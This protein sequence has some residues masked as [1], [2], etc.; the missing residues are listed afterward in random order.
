MKADAGAAPEGGGSK[1]KM[2]VI[3]LVALIAVAAGA[4]ITWFLANRSSA[5]AAAHKPVKLEPPVFVPI[6]PFTV[7]LQQETGEQYLQTA[8]TLQVSGVE[9]MQVIKDN[10]PQVRSR[11]LL[12]LSSKK[13]SE[14]SSTEGKKALSDEIIALI[15][16]PFAPNA[17]PQTVTGVFFTSFIVQ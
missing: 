11:L 3:I 10:M 12:L 8:F 14:L 6:E 7:N 1:K 2:I 17:P 13:A 15:N 4:G 16:Q 5:P 9:Q